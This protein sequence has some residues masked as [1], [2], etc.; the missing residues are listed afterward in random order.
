MTKNDEKKTK[1][2]TTKKVFN[3]GEKETRKGTERRPKICNRK[4]QDDR[5]KATKE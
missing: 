2:K 4:S 5:R 3:K 1:K